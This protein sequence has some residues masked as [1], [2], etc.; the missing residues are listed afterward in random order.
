MTE[1]SNNIQQNRVFSETR[2]VAYKH[3]LKHITYKC[4]YT[5]GNNNLS[6]VGKPRLCPECFTSR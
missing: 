1:Q 2:N 4:N 3:V 5:D 6:K